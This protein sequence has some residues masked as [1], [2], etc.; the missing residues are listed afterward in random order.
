MLKKGRKRARCLKERTKS[1]P[2]ANA[3]SLNILCSSDKKRGVLFETSPNNADALFKQGVAHAM[4]KDFG[5]SATSWAQASKLDHTDAMFNLAMCHKHGFGV[6]KNES[7]VLLLF[8]KA[9]QLED[10]EA[11]FYLGVHFTSGF[12]ADMQKAA[13]NFRKAAVQ[14][15]AS[16]Q[17][18]L[19]SCLMDGVGVRK[20]VK[21]AAWWWKKA[22]VQNLA[23]AQYNLGICFFSG[24][25]VEKN[26][27]KA[28]LMWAKA[29]ANNHA[30]S[31]LRLGHCYEAGVGVD[32]DLK[33][34]LLWHQRA[35]ANGLSQNVDPSKNAADSLRSISSFSQTDED[36]GS[37]S[38]SSESHLMTYK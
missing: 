14:G 18:N 24:I 32:T 20:D 34:A 26:D 21:M 35:A 10:A 33:S 5:R 6:A 16:A 28:F 37:R 29:A 31:Q 2:G 11:L 38:S 30:K 1:S 23:V 8:Q 19:G 22:A 25:G 7:K 17:F 15:F 9:A 36:C 4:K 12:K 3:E 13:I 27:R